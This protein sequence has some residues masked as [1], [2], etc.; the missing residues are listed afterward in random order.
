M[1]GGKRPGA[2]RP[3]IPIEQRRG[4]TTICVDDRTRKEL[5]LLRQN[6]LNMSAEFR[7]WVHQLCLDLELISDDFAD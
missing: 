6:G 3:A 4:M 1:R 7:G 5:R 2:G